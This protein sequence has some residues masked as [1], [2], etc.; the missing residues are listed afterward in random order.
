[1][2]KIDNLE[3][4][5]AIENRKQIQIDTIMHR[6]NDIQIRLE[7]VES[8]LSKFP[9]MSLTD[10][11]ITDF[12]KNITETSKMTSHDIMFGDVIRE[13]SPTIS[14][15]HIKSNNPCVITDKQNATNYYILK[16]LLKESLSSN[17]IKKAIGRTRE[18]TARLMKKLYDLK[19]VDRDITTKPFKYR[20][21]EQGKK[22][23]KE[24]IEKND[25]DS[26]SSPPNN[27]LFDLT[28]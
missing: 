18:H 24:Q 3:I 15:Q 22:Y 5:E 16:I 20:L 27:T 28:Q 21:T 25:S 7:L 17:E 4:I 13:T 8:T 26:S 1:L 2:P 12:S 23:I 10:R 6:I 14:H 11:N 19:L 9:D